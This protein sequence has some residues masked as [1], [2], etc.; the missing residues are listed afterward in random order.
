MNDQERPC[1]IKRQLKNLTSVLRQ[2]I[3]LTTN[4]D[5][6]PRSNKIKVLWYTLRG[7]QK[8]SLVYKTPKQA[9]AEKTTTTPHH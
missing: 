3:E 5:D 2:S 1:N 9:I 8:K 7:L 6:Q 4:S